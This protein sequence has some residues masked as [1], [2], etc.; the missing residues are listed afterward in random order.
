MTQLNETDRPN[1][2][3]DVVKRNVKRVLPCKLTDEELLRIARMRTGK[4][5]EHDQLVNDADIDA[6]KRKAQIKEYADEILAMR[7]EL[8]SGYQE[9]TI[10]TNEVF[11]K[12]ARGECWI[13]VYRLDSGEPTGERHPATPA[14]MQRYL[15]DFGAPGGG[16]LLAD[17]TRA[18]RSAQPETGANDNE[19][20]DGLPTDDES[21]GDVDD[22]DGDDK[23]DA[24]PKNKR[25]G[26]G[27]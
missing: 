4:E 5:A 21:E 24:T 15:P 19:V 2:T 3:L 9:R 11:E 13:V 6:K 20:P 18:Q 16:G 12:D 14:E 26:K 7:R 10:L 27:K 1:L 23:P 25:G 17:A 8:H 22:D